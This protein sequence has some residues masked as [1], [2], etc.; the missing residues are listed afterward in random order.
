MK[1][2]AFVMAGVYLVL[3]VCWAILGNLPTCLAFSALT[4]VSVLF[5]RVFDLEDDVKKL[6][7]KK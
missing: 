7:G 4:G 2:F 6:K 5:I 1:T 3:A